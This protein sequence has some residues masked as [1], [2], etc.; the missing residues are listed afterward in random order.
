[1][2][3]RISSLTFVGVRKWVNFFAIILR[4]IS[5]YSL[6][7]LRKSIFFML[8]ILPIKASC[9]TCMFVI[10]CLKTHL[11]YLRVFML[12][13][14]KFHFFSSVDTKTKIS[15]KQ[16]VFLASFPLRYLTKSLQILE[17]W[18]SNMLADLIS[19]LTNLSTIWKSFEL[20]FLHS[21]E[22]TG[23]LLVLQ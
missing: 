6:K 9:S 1:M 4:R 14:E 7:V 21:K 13:L 11:S 8:R 12:I 19:S 23:I 3:L 18:F 20:L 2:T 16:V 10:V 15:E 17:T 22:Q 5:V